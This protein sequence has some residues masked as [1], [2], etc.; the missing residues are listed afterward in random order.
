MLATDPVLVVTL[1]MVAEMALAEGSCSVL[2]SGNVGDGGVGGDAS[3]G[4]RD[5]GGVADGCSVGAN[6]GDSGVGGD[7]S[8]GSRDGGGGRLLCRKWQCWRRWCWR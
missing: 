1:V 5:G 8:D 2:L 6:V 7:T 3:D 4:V